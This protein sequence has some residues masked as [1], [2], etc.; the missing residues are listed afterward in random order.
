MAVG[1]MT[2]DLR[3]MRRW[4]ELEWVGGEGVIIITYMS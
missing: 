4:V 2:V 3:Y 1:L